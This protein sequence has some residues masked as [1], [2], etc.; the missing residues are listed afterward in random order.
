MWWGEKDP[1]GSTPSPPSVSLT[2]KPQHALFIWV[3]ISLL[4]RSHTFCM[5]KSEKAKQ[6]RSIYK[7]NKL[8]NCMPTTEATEEHREGKKEAETWSKTAA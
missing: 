7:K 6:V 4:I 8:N 1:R 2:R 3:P 5:P